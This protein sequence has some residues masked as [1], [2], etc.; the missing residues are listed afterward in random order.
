MVQIRIENDETALELKGQ[1]HD[2]VIEA[3][4]A[5][6]GAIEALRVLHKSDSF[7]RAAFEISIM[8]NGEQEDD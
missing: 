7:I 6:K 3:C 8:E 4:F 1:D 5:L 2:L